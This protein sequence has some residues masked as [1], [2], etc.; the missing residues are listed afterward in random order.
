MSSA[1]NPA[2][3]LHLPILYSFRRCPYAMRAR[4]A[5]IVGNVQCE[6]REVDL[7]NKPA[8]ML[9][10]SP[11]GTVPVLLFTDGT[12][13]EESLDIML[14]A[15]TQSGVSAWLKPQAGDLD[16]M[17]ELIEHNDGEFKQ[18]LDRYKYP[19][20]YAHEKQ[21]N[22]LYHRAQACAFLSQ[23]ETL[24]NDNGFLFGS[25][26]SLADLAIFPF[27]R[28]FAATDP[29]WFASLEYRRL[30]AWLTGWLQ[31]DLFAAAMHKHPVWQA[32]DAPRYLYPEVP[33][34][35]VIQTLVELH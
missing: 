35:D 25:H 27:V 21:P 17:L 30:Q 3:M 26:A 12:V 18:H 19:D 13:L 24:L 14:W 10:V 6:L 15:L 9:E 2:A 29:G 34:L 20:R 31:S 22:V 4:M 32:G 33:E 28:Q 5:L 8:E 23:L 16:D 7:G 1:N 11:K